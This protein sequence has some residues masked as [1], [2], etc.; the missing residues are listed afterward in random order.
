M[1]VLSTV[2]TR[3]RLVFEPGARQWRSRSRVPCGLMRPDRSRVCAPGVN[4]QVNLVTPVL[5]G[6]NA[7]VV[8]GCTVSPSATRAMRLVR[9]VRGRYHGRTSA[10]EYSRRAIAGGKS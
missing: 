6:A 8:A 10:S 1:R 5:Q 4:E 3:S 7:E 9:T 2:A